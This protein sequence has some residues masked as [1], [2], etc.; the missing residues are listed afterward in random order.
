MA[1]TVNEGG[2]LRELN[3]VTVNEGGV[4]Y[5]LDSVMANEGGVLREIY[6]GK[7]IN[8]Y[9]TGQSTGDVFEAHEYKT[10]ITIYRQNSTSTNMDVYIEFKGVKSGDT[11]RM[12]MNYRRDKQWL[13][14]LTW[15]GASDV[16]SNL[17]YSTVNIPN[18]YI[19]IYDNT[20]NAA[21]C[22]FQF[23]ATQ[24]NPKIYFDSTALDSVKPMTINIF[25]LQIN[26]EE[27]I[28]IPYTN[29]FFAYPTWELDA[30]N[31]KTDNSEPVDNLT[32]TSTG[33]KTQLSVD[34]GG[35]YP[36]YYTGAVYNVKAGMTVI[37]TVTKGSCYRTDSVSGGSEK[38]NVSMAMTLGNSSVSFGS[39][40]QLKMSAGD[41]L[42]I[43]TISD[44]QTM[45][46]TGSQSG[47]STTNYW[48]GDKADYTLE[49][50]I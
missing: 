44:R 35:K 7:A 16:T 41:T 33:W 18:G 6:G 36:T 49:F 43:K 40:Y 21:P 8:I 42:S 25:S 28:E 9:C 11:V 17:P 1:I 31:S 27:T 45:V 14:G 50:N 12:M 10:G 34:P 20:M 37:G 46:V 38:G 32:P 47:T 3:T 23:T 26:G 4:L 30:G 15:V 24:N 19:D 22:Y 13:V 48:Y 5:A 39:S 2:V 29:Y